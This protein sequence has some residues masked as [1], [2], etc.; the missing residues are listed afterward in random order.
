M[1][2]GPQIRKIFADKSFSDKLNA[3]EKRAWLSFISL[4][5]N[6]L[7][8]KRSDDY[9]EVVH[10]FLEAYA[11][12]GCRMSIKIHFLK[13]HLNFFPNNL[14]QFSDEQ[15]EKFHQELSQIEKRFEGKNRIRMLANYCWSL[16]RETDDSSYKRKRF[17]K[18][19]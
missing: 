8:N 7:G 5:E 14:G 17:S 13:S 4:C 16:K 1:F 10:E 3:V 19:F 2:V 12:M 11:E 9:V 18:H 15:G 6:F